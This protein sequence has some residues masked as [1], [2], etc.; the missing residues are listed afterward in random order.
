MTDRCP[1]C[2]AWLADGRACED[3]F[4][5]LLGWENEFPPLGEVHHLTVL[6]YYLQHPSRYSPEGLTHARELLRGFMEGSQTPQAVRRQQRDKV[7]SHNRD[8]T[9]TARPGAQGS[10][11][12][13][14]AWT[15]R[16][17]DVVAGGPDQYIETVRRWA[18]STWDVLK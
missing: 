16:A 1:E 18:R 14:M 7:S 10:Y 9:V 17:A 2:G 6:V 12:R 13:E 11:E 4:Y 15:M 3:D 8:W 5:T